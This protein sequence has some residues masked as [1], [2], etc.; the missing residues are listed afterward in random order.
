MLENTPYVEGERIVRRVARHVHKKA[1]VSRRFFIAMIESM[2]QPTKIRGLRLP[3][4][5]HQ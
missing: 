4:V 5:K 3:V 2:T 1:P